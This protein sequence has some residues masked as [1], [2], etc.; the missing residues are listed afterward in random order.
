V[1]VAHRLVEE[2]G[3]AGLAFHPR[4]ASQQ[5]RGRPDYELARE[6][7]EQLPVPVTIS[8]GLRDAPS[9]RTAFER[10]GAA[11]IMLARGS[12]GNPWLFAE[13]LGTRK[14][15]TGPDE[16]MAELEWVMDR[17]EEHLGTERAARY[18]RKF[19]PWYVERLAAAEGHSAVDRTLQDAL[20]RAPS[21][22]VARSFLQSQNLAAAA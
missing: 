7:V 4:H 5:H 16:V 18:L 11:A 13:L 9:A 15:A 22:P 6:L 10:T 1:R 12:L 14:R 21:L 17:A 3:V 8:G 20:Q 19:Y 2:A